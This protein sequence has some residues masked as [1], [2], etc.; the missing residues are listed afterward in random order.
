MAHDAT[1]LMSR[2]DVLVAAVI[3]H[4]SRS[5]IAA[6]LSR[7]CDPGAAHADELHRALASKLYSVAPPM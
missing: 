1:K 7:S 6:R 5:L 4:S 3:L 2:R